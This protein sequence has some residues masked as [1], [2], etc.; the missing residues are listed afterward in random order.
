MG[1]LFPG[2]VLRMVLII[3]VKLPIIMKNFAKS[4]LFVMAMVS[5]ATACQKKTETTETT[6]MDSTSMSMDSTSM[7]VDTMAVDSAS[8]APMAA[9]SAK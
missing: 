7:A 2:W 6:V 1:Y 4:A 3:N 9:D 5:L 8:T